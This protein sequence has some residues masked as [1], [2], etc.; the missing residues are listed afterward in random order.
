VNDRSTFIG[1]PNAVLPFVSIG[2]KISTYIF[3]LS[4]DSRSV[5]STQTYVVT[6]YK[7]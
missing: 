6:L 3:N 4:Y 1:I 7:K 5:W 2:I